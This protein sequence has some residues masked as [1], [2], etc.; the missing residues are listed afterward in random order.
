MSCEHEKIT[1]A[2]SQLVQ[3]MQ[4]ILWSREL[5]QLGICTIIFKRN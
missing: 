5:R 1:E 2:D 3:I 4:A